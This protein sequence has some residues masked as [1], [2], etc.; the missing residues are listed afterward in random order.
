MCK[1]LII[2]IY[3]ILNDNNKLLSIFLIY[4]LFIHFSLIYTELNSQFHDRK[5]TKNG[6][7]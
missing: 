1:V 4:L 6:D 7:F 2:K 3:D 5:E